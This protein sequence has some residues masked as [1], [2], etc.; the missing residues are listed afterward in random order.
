MKTN[1]KV[2]TMICAVLALLFG[3]VAFVEGVTTEF[4]DL[5][6]NQIPPGWTLEIVNPG[7]GSGIHDGKL[8]AHNTDGA[9][10]LSKELTPGAF[11]ELTFQYDSQLL[12]YSY[13]GVGTSIVVSFTDG[14]VFYI[15]DIVEGY[16]YG[17]NRAVHYRFK[18]SGA[19][20]LFDTY[21]T[22]EYIEYHHTLSIRDG[23]FTLRSENGGSVLYDEQI[24]DA[25]FAMSDIQKISYYTM[26]N[27]GNDVWMDNLRFTTEPVPEPAIEAVIDIDPDTLNLQSKGE[28][29]TCYIELAEGYDVDDI[30][31]GTVMLNDQVQAESHPTEI[32]D[33]DND[34][35][36]D[37]MVKF[38]RSAVQG[39]LQVGDEVEI[40]VT[41]E[42]N[43]E[44]PF[45]GID[46]I[47]VIDKGGKK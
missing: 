45:E 29:I 9:A 25:R 23:V 12:G 27:T 14:E 42:L 40:T 30:D 33:Y 19:L 18:N 47:R 21:G 38:D 43:D 22:A 34:D 4:Y 31:V 11:S 7:T 10:I 5:D 20:T 39:I 15:Q 13:W 8:W 6:D 17:D 16:R 2:M 41:G 26:A 44:T 1:T 35:I 37:L 28:W 3:D 46:T 32:G 24:N 36:S